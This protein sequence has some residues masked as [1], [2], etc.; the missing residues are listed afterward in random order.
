MDYWTGSTKDARRPTYHVSFAVGQS[1]A[2]VLPFAADFIQNPQPGRVIFVEDEKSLVEMAAASF[3]TSFTE[4]NEAKATGSNIVPIAQEVVRLLGQG[5]Q[6][7]DI[8]AGG[9]GSRKYAVLR[10]IKNVYPDFFEKRGVAIAFVDSANAKK[11]NLEK[12][13]RSHM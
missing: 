7:K 5:L 9:D 13:R 3:T 6:Q 2:K 8:C 1:L 10:G 12:F 4:I 11:I